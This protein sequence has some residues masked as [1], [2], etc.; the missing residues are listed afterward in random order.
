MK[1]NIHFHEL[2]MEMKTNIHFHELYMEMKT[3]IHFHEL[4]ME[5]K[6]NIH[7]H[8]LY[9]EMKTNIHFYVIYTEM[10]TIWATNIHFHVFYMEMVIS[11]RT[12]TYS[13]VSSNLYLGRLI[14]W[15]GYHPLN[16]KYMYGA[17]FQNWAESP[18]SLYN[19]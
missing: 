12:Q 2:Y 17:I 4:Y 11:P 14:L 18:I 16:Y 3:N 19:I 9:M 15:G 10:K 6:T 8:E 1:T 7:F 13:A 5:M